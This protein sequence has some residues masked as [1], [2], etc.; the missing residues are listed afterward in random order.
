MNAVEWI[1]MF[2]I[3]FVTVAGVWL[4]VHEAGDWIRQEWRVYKN[5]RKVQK[6]YDEEEDQ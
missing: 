5:V 4:C 1:V 2:Y 3:V 6:F